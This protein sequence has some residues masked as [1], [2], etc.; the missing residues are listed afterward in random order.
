MLE[1]DAGREAHVHIQPYW[2]FRDLLEAAPDGIIEVE[3]DGTI[4]LLN[5]AAEKMFGYRREE[6][7]GQ[8]IEALVPSSVRGRHHEH[9]DHYAEHPVTRPMGVGLELFAQR[10]DGSQ[11][12]VEI[13]LSPIRSL[14]G[15]R[16]IA[17]VRDI[18]TRKQAEAKI[19][20]IHQQFAAELAATNQQLEIRNREVERANRL[21][22]EFLASMSH[23]LRT[24]LH[25]VIG[26]ADLLAEELKGTLNADQRRFVGHI[27]RDSRHLLELINDVLDLSKIESG[28][29]QL[30]PELFDTA[31]AIAETMASLRPLAENKQIQIHEKLDGPLTITA[32]RL[33]FKEI[34][35]N[36]V[37]NAI[38]FTPER[39][40]I[41][42]EGHEQPET[43]AFAVTDTG[44]GIDP[45]E[46]QAIFDKFYQLGSTTRGVREGTGLG[47]A[48]TKSLVEMHGGRI[49]LKSAPGEGSRFQFFLPRNGPE[50]LLRHAENKKAGRSIVLVGAGKE[51]DRIVDYLTQKGYEVIDAQTLNQVLPSGRSARPAAIVLDLT[52]LGS[53]NWQIFQQL[54]ASNEMAHVP[55]LMLTAAQDQGL[56]VSLGANAA[57]VKPVDCVTLVKI[58][59]KEVLDTPGEPSRVLIVSDTQETREILD[60]TL[61]SA[62]FLPVLASS[63]AQA[64]EMLARCPISAI[65]IDLIMPGMSGLELILH[66]RQN[67]RVAKAPIVLLTAKGMEQDDEQTLN[68][69]ANALFL[70]AFPWKEEFLSKIGE[71]LE[72]VIDRGA[73]RA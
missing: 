18:T 63:G 29:L 56:A 10:K 45:A 66:I 19:N 20:T 69:Q 71:L 73:A 4:V 16:V 38:K 33:R 1:A 24:P 35:Y 70:E 17:I 12:P 5:A 8:L 46:Q 72:N 32:D 30:Y 65:V 11:F 13:S 50:A 6:L 43:I 41:T 42:L 40:Q 27:Q 58:L 7:L 49:E 21:K 3:R 60:G 15:S 37:S 26:F 68:R 53:A 64:L 14:Q 28:R 67:A 51:H 34:L 25:T 48:I 22:S 54:R 36:L 59:R 57:V 62:A 55:A 47:L 52:A 31:G 2:R 44:V 39:G 9:R 61:R 23:E